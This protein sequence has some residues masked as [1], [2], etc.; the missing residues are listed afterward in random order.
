MRCRRR[1]GVYVRYGRR[2]REAR[3]ADKDDCSGFEIATLRVAKERAACRNS[4]ENAAY[5][6]VFGGYNIEGP[7]LKRSAAEKREKTGKKGLDRRERGVV[8]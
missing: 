8:Y 5:A 2:E 3:A 1:K 6:G 7:R 4:A